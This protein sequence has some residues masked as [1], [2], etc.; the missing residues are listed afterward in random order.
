VE[1][2]PDTNTAMEDALVGSGVAEPEDATKIEC[3]L[4]NASIGGCKDALPA[5]R[6]S[7]DDE[8]EGGE[9]HQEDAR[10]FDNLSFGGV[11]SSGAS[12]ESDS[13]PTEYSGQ[14]NEEQHAE[15]EGI[16]V[17]DLSAH[18]VDPYEDAMHD[19]LDG[20]FHAFLSSKPQSFD[21]NIPHGEVCIYFTCSFNFKLV[22]Y[23][24]VNTF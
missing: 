18:D 11:G 13:N 16:K 20:I 24:L 17:V 6:S 21:S 19:D 1:H 2:R 7:D 22:L 15:K 9:E 14:G 5:L 10:M 12:H 3:A 4:R 23:L 8:D